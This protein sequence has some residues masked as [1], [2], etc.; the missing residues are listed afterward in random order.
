LPRYP[1]SKSP[2]NTRR[3][4]VHHRNYFRDFFDISVKITR[5]PLRQSPV[6]TRRTIVP[7]RNYFRGFFDI[8][9][10]IAT[11]SLQPISRKHA[12][13]HRPSPQLLPRL[14]RHCG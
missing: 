12:P 6:N 8:A 5:Y 9:V 3:T 10:K 13:H 7:H 14:L 4:I 1:L 11:L 2:A